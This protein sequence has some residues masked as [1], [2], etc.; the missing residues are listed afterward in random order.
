MDANIIIVSVVCTVVFSTVDGLQSD[1]MK[2]SLFSLILLSW[3][4]YTCNVRGV[5]N[6]SHERHHD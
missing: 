5:P 6:L 4:G 1:M 2:G 3:V